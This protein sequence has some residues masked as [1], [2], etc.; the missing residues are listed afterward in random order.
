MDL[1]ASVI[2]WVSVK[3]SDKPADSHHPYGH[4]KVENI[5]G[6]AEAFL[7]FFAAGW[8]I[9]ESIGKL[10]RPEEIEAIPVGVIVML[11]SAIVN[12]VVSRRLYRVSRETDSIAL[13]ADALHLR[14]DVYTS[15]GVAAGLL[16]IWISGYHFMDPVIAM[17]IAL[18]IL[19]ESFSLFKRAY[20]PLL[21]ISLPEKEIREIRQIIESFGMEE[22]GYHDLRTRKAGA[23]RYVDFHLNLSEQMTVR[24]AHDLCD[25]IEQRIKEKFHLTEVTIHVEYI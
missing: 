20:G 21:D 18:L 12:L 17:C 25:R 5:S 9:Y 2:A 13:E 10:I 4:G 11:I 3:I 15:A 23:Y 19:K 16:F 7:I 8:I 14:T 6:V 1:L 24:E 22:T